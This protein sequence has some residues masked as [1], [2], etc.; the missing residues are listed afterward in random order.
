M[1]LADTVLKPFMAFQAFVDESESG[2]ILVLGGVIASAEQWVKFTPEWERLLPLAPLGR[3]LA[4]N[5][6]FSEMINAGQ[7]RI[8]SIP[9]F[10]KL[11]ED[12]IPMTLSLDLFQKDIDQAKARVKTPNGVID[13]GNVATPYMLGITHVVMWFGDNMQAVEE[14]LG[15]TQ[16]IDFTFDDRSER[17]FVRKA[18]ESSV[19]TLPPEQRARFG[20]EPR[21]GNDKK[22]L[23]LQ[24]A[25]YI[26]GWTRYW[27]E[28]NE[29]PE[30]GASYLGGHVVRG[31]L[32]PH[33]EMHLTEDVIANYLVQIATSNGVPRVY[34]SAAKPSG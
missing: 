25:D 22:F 27:L 8:D 9:A 33:V 6:K 29:V 34:D 30:I 14:V 5:F 26:A 20:E 17:K 4:R 23:E 3:D 18:W 13:W 24:A 7:F 11:I 28:R 15:T 2:G 19:E 10:S 31:N 32:L 12:H 16:P 1:G 21:F